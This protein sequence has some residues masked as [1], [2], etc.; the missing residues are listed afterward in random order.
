[1]PQAAAVG[2]RLSVMMFLQFFIWGSWYVTAPL[3]L[4]KLGFGGEEFFWTYSV[5]PIAG[6]ISPFFLGMV[7]DRFFASERV[8]GAMHLLGAAAMYGALTVMGGE[9]PSPSMINTL[10]FAHML[11]YYPTLALTNTL[12]L[13]NMTDAEKQFPLIRVFGT[14]GWIVAGF[15]LDQLG[16]SS[17]RD[18]FYLTIGASVLLGLYSFTL[19]HTPPPSAGKEVST[20]ELLGVDAFVL[21]KNRSF[22]IFMVSSFLICI[23]LAF[24]Y[25]LAARALQQT[26]AENVATTMSFGQVSEIFFMLAMPLFFK[27]LG[28]KWMLV[29]GMAAWVIRYGLFA[30]ASPQPDPII[31]MMI[32]GIVLHG[33]CYD[34]FFVTGQIYTDKT[35]PPAIRGQAQG[36]LVLFTLGIGMFIGAQCAGIIEATFSPPEAVALQKD[37]VKLD[38]EIKAKRKDLNAYLAEQGPDLQKEWDEWQTEMAGKQKEYEAQIEKQSATE[39]EATPT[40]TEQME[41]WETVLDRQASAPFEKALEMQFQINDLGAQQAAKTNERLKLLD[42]KWIWLI[43]CAGAAVVMIMFSLLFQDD[44]RTARHRGR[45]RRCLCRERSRRSPRAARRDDRRVTRFLPGRSKN[46]E[47][48]D[49]LV[50]SRRGLYVL[51]KSNNSAS[52]DFSHYV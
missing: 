30:V 48:R 18:M 44:T 50:I 29:V 17:S 34:F 46:R 33:I 21:F 40:P 15:M 20:R 47:E 7:A 8:L 45:S 24:Y 36:M 27:R 35:A 28:V 5:G 12:A 11:C 22:L 16:W 19:P 2:P 25:Q 52:G 10:F 38:T 49:N 43:P 41:A 23:P 9:E 1:M 6:I 51:K 31:W 42:W 26:G 32:L 4:G 37:V 3:Y 14:I 13:H 39:E